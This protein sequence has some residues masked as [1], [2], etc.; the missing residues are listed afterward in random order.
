MKRIIYLLL[1]LVVAAFAAACTKAPLELPEVTNPTTPIR[2]STLLTLTFSPSVL[3]EVGTS[4]SYDVETWIHDLSIYL[5]HKTTQKRSTYFLS[6]GSSVLSVSLPKGAYELYAIV[7][8]G[9]NMCDWSLEDWLVF[10]APAEGDEASMTHNGIM[11]MSARQSFV[12]DRSMAIE[13]PLKRAPAKVTF[14]VSLSPSMVQG[15]AKILYLQLFNCTGG[16]P[17]FF[18]AIHI[19][20]MQPYP[21]YEASEANATRIKKTHYLPENMQGIVAAVTAPSMRSQQYAPLRATYLVVRV[22]RNDKMIDYR[23]YLGENDTND[24]NVRR[25]THYFYD[26]SIEGENPADLRVSSVSINFYGGLPSTGAGGYNLPNKVIWNSRVAYAELN[27]DTANNDPDNVYSVSFR[28]LSG[29]FSP[30]WYMQYCQRGGSDDY[31]HFV[32]NSWVTCHRGNG[33]SVL[34]IAFHNGGSLDNHTTDNLFEFT[35]RD[36]YGYAKSFTLQTYER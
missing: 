17:L 22:E 31:A 5:V 10:G 1:P 36:T 33:K 19:R 2:D 32:E 35:V 28:K 12:L 30:S 16:I 18:D 20:A 8:W 6:N 7:N 29:T 26:I 25:N 11:P 4:K 23:I 13:V 14:D 3:A 24:F 9:H 34:F 27:I 21:R 15:G